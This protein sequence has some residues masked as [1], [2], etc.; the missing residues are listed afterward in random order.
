MNEYEEELKELYTL[1]T[2]LQKIEKLVSNK[3]LSKYEKLAFETLIA[4]SR[5][6]I[7]EVCID[8]NLEFNHNKNYEIELNRDSLNKQNSIMLQ[9]VQLYDLIDGVYQDEDFLPALVI[10]ISKIN[11][12]LTNKNSLQRQESSFCI[13]I[14]G[15]KIYKTKKERS[16]GGKKTNSIFNPQR[17]QAEIIYQE[18]KNSYPNLIEMFYTNPNKNKPKTTLKEML[19]KSIAVDMDERTLQVWVKELLKNDGVLIKNE[20][21]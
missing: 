12:K 21:K 16:N 20:N 8:R 9:L 7:N 10:V 18:F 17:K 11:K 5:H 19:K 4:S 6:K 13:N 14:L 2:L 1:Q 3:E 15:T